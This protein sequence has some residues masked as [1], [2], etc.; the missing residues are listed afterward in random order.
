VDWGDVMTMPN[1]FII[2]AQKA[3]TTSLYYYL[4]QHPE[5]YMSPR[6]EPHFFDGMQSRYRWARGRLPPVTDLEDYRALFQGVTDENAIGEASTSY[7]YSALAP[8]LIEK[9]VPDARIIAVLRNPADRA[10]SNFLHCVRSG[11]E[12]LTSFTEGLKAEEA[13]KR[14]NWA[15]LWYY[16]EKGFYYAQVKRYL[17]TFDPGQIK[18]Y[19]Y[20]DLRA[21]PS[22]VLSD[23]FEFL[24]VD[25][26]FVPDLAIEHNTAGLPRNKTLYVMAQ[27]LGVLSP[28]LKLDTLERLL[29]A[30]S[31]RRIKSR[32]FAK[33]PAFP[34]EV[35]Q[36][37]LA[38]YREDIQKLEDLI[39]RDLSVWLE[40]ANKPQVSADN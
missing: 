28:A 17:D 27:R 14:A 39:Q 4:E 8:V 40:G 13:R 9:S 32:F 1:F 19:L 33:P 11:R 3:G 10:Y 34:A 20:D 31:I 2:G 5:V 22:D 36:Q 6:K 29:P 12:P 23:M 26:T 30:G 16:K 35:R 24:G 15:P 18:I 37:L 25:E 21:K 7:I 38:S